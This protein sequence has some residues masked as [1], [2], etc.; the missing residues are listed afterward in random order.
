MSTQTEKGEI[1]A[2]FSPLVEDVNHAFG[3]LLGGQTVHTTTYSAPQAVARRLNM[4][5]IRLP[6]ALVYQKQPRKSWRFFEEFEYRKHIH[7]CFRKYP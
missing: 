3:G 6:P 2:I 1:L 7:Y 4:Q 5:G